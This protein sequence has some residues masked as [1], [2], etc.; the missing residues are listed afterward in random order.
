MDKLETP[1]QIKGLRDGLLITLGPGE[2]SELEPA[3]LAHIGAQQ[4]FFRGARVALDVGVQSLR[5]N[6]LSA[7]RDM[8]SDQGVSLWAV[9]SESAVTEKTAQLLGLATRV[10]KPRP[11][12]ERTYTPEDL[13]EEKALYIGKTVRSGTRIQFPGH[14]VIMGDVNPGA[15][16]IAEGNVIIWGH[17]RGMIHAGAK[18][19]TSAVICALNLS[20]TQL[21]IADELTSIAKP[22]ERPLPEIARLNGEGKLSTEPWQPT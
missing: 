17:A 8:L 12:E 11:E 16:I 22:Q 1:F 21:R 2:W 3:L 9:M 10:S 15:E 18:G 14:V 13:G 7:L 19:D 5:V 20:P 6:E 4:A